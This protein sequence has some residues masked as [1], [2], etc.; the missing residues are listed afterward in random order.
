VSFGAGASAENPEDTL[1]LSGNL[2]SMCLSDLLQWIALGRKTGKL[3]L[4]RDSLNKFIHF[5]DGRIISSSSNSP[6]E[7]F[8][9]FLVRLRR[10]TEEQL[11]KALLRQHQ[12]K[13]PLG[14]ILVEEGLLDGPSVLQVLEV[15]TRETIFDMF[16][17]TEGRFYFYEEEPPGDLHLLLAQDVSALIFE[18]IKRIDD[19]TRIREHIPCNGTTFRVIA[20]PADLKDDERE[21]IRF[22]ERGLTVGQIAIET[23]LSEYEVSMV[24]CRLLQNQ[25]VAI[26]S[27]GEIQKPEETVRVIKD[28]LKK[29]DAEFKEGWYDRSLKTFQE[30]LKL[31]SLNQYAKIY[32]LKIQSRKT[33]QGVEDAVPREAVLS[34]RPDMQE[35]DVVFTPQEVVV[36]S[37]VNGERK[38]S[39]ILA[40]SPLPE[41]E[42]LNI[43]RRLLT[44]NIL[45]A[46][47]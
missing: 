10:I 1:A 32:I 23:N 40:V 11:F 18:G 35:E 17:W 33:K 4:E 28:L 47:R 46:A 16:S 36:M 8:G 20:Q 24:L 34:L 14:E 7:S 43:I 15:K 3:F 29:G 21:I 45:T 27:T 25:V 9:H 5:K 38:I 13:K 31:D 44:F 19:W 26:D 30:V 41:E 6:R 22:V 42:T 39:D 37:Q 2:R 12:R